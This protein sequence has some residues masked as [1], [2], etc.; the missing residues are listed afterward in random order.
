MFHQF[1]D[2]PGMN[3]FG[4]V[5]D[6]PLSNYRVWIRLD[7]DITKIHATSCNKHILTN[8]DPAWDMNIFNQIHLGLPSK[9]AWHPPPSI[10]SA[11]SLLPSPQVDPP[12]DRGSTQKQRSRRTKTL[13]AA[14]AKARKFKGLLGS[15]ETPSGLG[16][17]SCNG[18]NTLSTDFTW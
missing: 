5:L 4:H 10:I 17:S 8:R 1:L 6:D 11:V 3:I 15:N 13:Q 9:P 12:R 18:L 7:P 16:G 2:F 14:R